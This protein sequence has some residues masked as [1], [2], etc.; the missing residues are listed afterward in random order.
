[1]ELVRRSSSIGRALF[2]LCFKVKYCHKVFE[3]KEFEQRCRELLFEAASRAGIII[4]EIG[5][6]R[7]HVHLIADIGLHS[8]PEAVKLLKGYSAHKLLDEFPHVKKRYFWGSGLWSPA[9]FFESVG[10]DYGFVA[11]YVRNQ[12]N[13]AGL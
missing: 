4:Y 12:G 9:I 11:D 10:Q 6:D 3:N 8:I 5:F 1:M 2:H 7:D 13:T